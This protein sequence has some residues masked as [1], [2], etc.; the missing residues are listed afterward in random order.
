M[1]PIAQR[2]LRGSPL[3]VAAG[4]RSLEVDWG[5]LL[6]V[7]LLVGLAGM[8][9]FWRLGEGS[10]SDYDEADYAQSAREMWWWSDLNTPR[11]NGMEFFDKPPLC[12]WLTA[13][14]YRIFGVNEFSARVVSAT[15]GLL[16][17]ALT[18]VL[19]REVFESRAVGLGAALT[20]LGASPNLFS[21]GY[22]FL[23]LARVGMLDMPLIATMMIAVWWVWRATADSCPFRRR[24]LVALGL[25]LGLG[26]M[27]KSVAGFIAIGIVAL[28][29]V[30]AVPASRWWRRETL[31][32]LALCT[33]VAAPWHIGQL[34]IWGRHFWDSYMVSLT[35]GYVTG[36][37]G[38]TRDWLFYVRSIQRGFPL[39]YPLVGAA[40]LL[41][42]LRGIRDLGARI[43]GRFDTDKRIMLLLCWIAVPF[44]LYSLSRSR[45]G[46][47]MI[48][49]YPALALLVAHILV[50]GLRR[51]LSL[52]EDGRWARAAGPVVVIFLGAVTLAAGTWLPRAGDF[53]PDVKRVATFGAHVLD[54]SDVLVNYWPGSYWIRPSALFYSDRPLLLVTNQTGLRSLSGRGSPL[55]V[56]A[57]RADWQLADEFGE[58]VYCSGEYVLVRLAPVASRSGGSVHDG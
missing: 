56:L 45:I 32:G 16:A 37:Q 41:G 15:A 42:F 39:L 3:R 38:H 55:Y 57:D 29:L 33:I 58:L 13:A 6:V 26:L 1:R 28:Y 4:R 18:Y 24:Y 50:T 20:L 27:M 53:N 8:L 19:G 12:Y 11:W 9:I 52:V 22:N 21:H 51:A 30:A 10:L 23:S 2:R 36:E 7:V 40:V 31:W 25:P 34:L 43:R 47:Y 48:P 5:D 17:V 46:W 54:E 14:A 44:L 35:V 49:I